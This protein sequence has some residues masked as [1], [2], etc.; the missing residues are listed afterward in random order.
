MTIICRKGI[1]GRLLVA[2]LLAGL[3][4]A[5]GLSGYEKK[6]RVSTDYSHVFLQPDSSSAIVDTVGRGTVLSLLYGGKM[7]RTWYYVCFKGEKSGNTKSGYILDSEVEL[8]FDPLLTI[9]IQEEQPGLRVEYPPRH[10]EEMDWG[11]TKKEIVEAEGKPT[12]QLKSQGQDVLVYGQKVINLDCDI[13]YRFAANKLRQTRFHFQGES[14]DEVAGLD[15]YRKVKD[16][17]VRKYG[18]PGSENMNWRDSA[19]KEDFSSWGTAVG[20]GQLELRSRWLTP[21]TEIVASLSGADG[22]TDLVVV[23]TGIRLPELASKHQDED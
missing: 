16:A 2:T 6:V 11:I 1:W 14:P 12:S 10:F 3:P 21:R 23:F 20:L 4:T 7:K 15:D 9:T 8:L 22:E 18:K 5:G 17:L 13:E 19:Y